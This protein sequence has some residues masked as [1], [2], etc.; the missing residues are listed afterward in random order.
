MKLSFDTMVLKSNKE[1]IPSNAQINGTEKLMMTL[2]ASGSPKKKAVY[3][4]KQMSENRF[5]EYQRQQ[6]A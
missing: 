4:K 2:H 1:Q 3:L 5:K 6:L